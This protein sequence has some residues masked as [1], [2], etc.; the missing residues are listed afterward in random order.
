MLTLTGPAVEAIRSLT[1]KPGVPEKSGLRIAHQDTAGSLA[2]SIAA[3][4]EVDDEILEVDGIR[5]F[6]HAEAAAM[7]SNR[8]LSARVDD[9]G[10]VFRIDELPE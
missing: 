1:V 3:E 8:T 10:P 2:L 6:L 4:P 9:H 5:V 7:L